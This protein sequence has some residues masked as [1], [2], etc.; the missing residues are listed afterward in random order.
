[1]EVSILLSLKTSLVL[2]IPLHFL[3]C[4]AFLSPSPLTIGVCII[5]LSHLV[6]AKPAAISTQ[7]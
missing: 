5:P 3:L 7:L 1:M 4:F 2:A 6:G